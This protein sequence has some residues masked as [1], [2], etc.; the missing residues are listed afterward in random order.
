MKKLFILTLAVAMGAMSVSAQTTGLGSLLGRIAAATDTTSTTTP[1]TPTTSTAGS[2]L[3]SLLGKLAAGQTATD[4]SATATSTS[5]LGG[6]LG[7]LLSNVL[8]NDNVTVADMVGTWKY[9][10]PAVAFESDDLLAKAGGAAA[11]ATLETK[12]VDYY[13]KIGFDGM[14]LTVAAD[15]TFTMKSKRLS[16]AGYLTQGEQPGQ[17]QFHITLLSQIPLGTYTASVAILSNRMTVTFDTS[18]LMSMVNKIATFAGS[19]TLSTLNTMLQQFDGMEA[20][21][22]LTKTAD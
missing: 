9:D 4:S 19:K 22:N 17:I 2:A 15:S 6:M 8:S 21:Y 1:T 13:K 7:N 3:G 12:L 18:K 11:A 10:S 20:G 14:T 16:M 5:G